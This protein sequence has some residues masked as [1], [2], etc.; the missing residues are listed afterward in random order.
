MAL[1]ARLEFRQGQQLVM[2]PQLQQA[3]RLLQLS[4]IELNAFVEAELERNP[5]LEREEVAPERGDGGDSREPTADEASSPDLDFDSAAVDYAGAHDTDMEN[6]Y[7]EAPIQDMGREALGPGSGPEMGLATGRSR[8]RF[9]AAGAV[10][11]FGGSL[12]AL[13]QRVAL[14]FSFDERIELDVRELQ[15]PDGLL[16][17][18]CHHQLLA[19]PKFKFGG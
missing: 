16:Q 4:N 8:C 13:K 1:S 3:I 15:Q 5:L 19:L 10:T 11:A 17:L 9:V 12:F 7:P 18:G 2:T 14:E 6:V